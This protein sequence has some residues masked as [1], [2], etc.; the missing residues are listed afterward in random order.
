MVFKGG[1]VEPV[2]ATLGDVERLDGALA[3]TLARRQFAAL[4]GELLDVFDAK[5]DR[6]AGTG[7]RLTSFRGCIDAIEAGLVGGLGSSVEGAGAIAAD[8]SVPG[9]QGLDRK[10]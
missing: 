4:H 10:S 5:S 1:P 6:I 3:T 2:G 9:G 8:R 7:G